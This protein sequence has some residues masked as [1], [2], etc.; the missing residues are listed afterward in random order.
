MYMYNICKHTFICTLR[1]SKCPV[2]I[3][4]DSDVQGIVFGV[5]TFPVAGE[6]CMLVYSLCAPAPFVILSFKTTHWVETKVHGKSI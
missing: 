4:F 1:T 3:F 2:Q 5:T 6:V